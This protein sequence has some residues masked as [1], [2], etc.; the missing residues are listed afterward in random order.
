M[1]LSSLTSQKHLVRHAQERFSV[2]D[3][4]LGSHADKPAFEVRRVLN[5]GHHYAVAE[6]PFIEDC[7]ATLMLHFPIIAILVADDL[8]FLL[9]LLTLLNRLSLAVFWKFLNHLNTIITI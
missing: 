9:F 3:W 4:L 2:L 7:T 5:F 1:R 8:G 6:A